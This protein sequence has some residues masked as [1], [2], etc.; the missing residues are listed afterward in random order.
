VYIQIKYSKKNLSD[1]W[2]YH[3]CIYLTW[4]DGNVGILLQEGIITE[5]SKSSNWPCQT[6]PEK[7][8]CQWD[9]NDD[10]LLG[11]LG[12]L[13]N[14]LDILGTSIADPA[15]KVDE[16]DGWVEDITGMAITE[17]QTWVGDEMGE[18]ISAAEE[19]L[20]GVVVESSLGL[21]D[22]G[23]QGEGWG[24]AFLILQWKGRGS[25]VRFM[26]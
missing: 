12:L 8:P 26:R 22:G 13:A 2:L 20:L 19:T 11:R 5:L 23:L 18:A 24:R 4:G 21:L 3:I 15:S 16:A 9:I 6:S 14:S 25:G 10:L 1:I 7:L 17:G